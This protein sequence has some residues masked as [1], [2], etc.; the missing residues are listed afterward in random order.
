MIK[1]PSSAALCVAGVLFAA[2]PF[3]TGCSRGDTM[4]LAAPPSEWARDLLA[5]RADKDR[6]FATSEDTPLRPGDRG[7]F[8]G[9]EYWEPA[10]RWRFAGWVRLYDRPE[11]LTLITTNGEER[12]CEKVG[13]VTFTVDGRRC[14]LQVY[15]L[16]DVERRE[17]GDGLFLPFTDATT[18]R[19]T[20]AAGRYVDLEGPEGGPYVLDFNKAYNPLCA[21][22]MP[23]RFQCP[24]TPRENRLDVRVEAGERG[25]AKHDRTPA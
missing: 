17:G 21:Y 4:D 3:G 15:R 2:I 14:R 7:A 6:R 19:D 16:L 20:Y 23:E 18:G 1:T 22:G 8:A 25:F 9:L 13:Y 11:P 12:P 5:W 10:A 24:V